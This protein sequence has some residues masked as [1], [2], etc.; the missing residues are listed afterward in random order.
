[1]VFSLFANNIIECRHSLGVDTAKGEPLLV[2]VAK[3]D[4]FHGDGRSSDS[5][6]SEWCRRDAEHRS[7]D[8]TQPVAAAATNA[9]AGEFCRKDCAVP[10]LVR[11]AFRQFSDKRRC[12]KARYP[13]LTPIDTDRTLLAG[14]IDFHHAVAKR[15]S[16]LQS[17][18]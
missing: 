4:L 9:T 14:V 16:W 13:S 3:D 5:T 2:E 7:T 1:M 6:S 8:C 15:L 18:H 11:L 10:F 17:C 12:H